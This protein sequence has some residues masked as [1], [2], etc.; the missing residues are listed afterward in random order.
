MNTT[1]TF[2]G[3]VKLACFARLSTATQPVAHGVTEH[4]S[5][6]WIVVALRSGPASDQIQTDTNLT[7]GVDLPCSRQVGPRILEF[8]ATVCRVNSMPGGMRVF[9]SVHR[10]K[11]VDG[12][13]E[14]ELPVLTSWI[15]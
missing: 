9:A 2:G 7:V 15:Q 8:A 12:E 13:R 3:E 10:M 4:L 14:P 11:V 5:G 6:K 1:D